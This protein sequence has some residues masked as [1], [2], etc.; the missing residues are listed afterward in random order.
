MMV[1]LVQ[2]LCPLK[3][4][5]NFDFDVCVLSLHGQSELRQTIQVIRRG[6]GYEVVTEL[7]SGVGYLI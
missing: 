7:Y 6:T 1:Q 2:S 5:C 4:I 3:G